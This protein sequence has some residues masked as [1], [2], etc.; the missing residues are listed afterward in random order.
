MEMT[1]RNY[2]TGD[3]S[4]ILELF[5]EVF[6]E[7]LSLEVWKWRFHENPFGKGIV[8][9]L[10]DGAKLVGHYAVVPMKVQIKGEVSNG[11]FSMTTMTHPNYRG[12]GIFPLL[13]EE[14]YKEAAEGGFEFVFGFPNEN[15]Y[16]GFV[17]KL[18]WT[19]FGNMY[20]WQ[21]KIDNSNLHTEW[22][23][24]NY[25]KEISEFDDSVD[26]LWE[27]IK[28]DYSVIV[29]R[30]K[31]F[32]NWRF[33]QNPEV[34]YTK[35]IISDD[36]NK[37]AGYV[38]FKIWRSGNKKKGHIVD[39]L[40]VSDEKIVQTILECAYAHFIKYGVTDISCWSPRNCFYTDVLK[41]EGFS[42]AKMERIFFGIR[43]FDKANEHL[44][45]LE[46]FPNWYLTMGDSDVF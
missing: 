40:S 34:D 9:L 30:T 33:V 37:I 11:V 23:K 25:V 1:L 15:S 29:P 26:F 31:S 41:G 8:K 3:E 46:D 16:E 14:T 22:R 6:N 39:M 21:R 45:V 13:G 17:K 36:N 19:G 42:A 20:V 10:Y 28:Q 5:K 44:K 2:R 12:R 43:I 27:K 32:L 7:K 35:Y 18:R 38:V 24:N 4:S